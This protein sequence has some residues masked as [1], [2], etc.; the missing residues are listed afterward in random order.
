MQLVEVGPLLLMTVMLI[1]TETIADDQ[2]DDAKANSALVGPLPPSH[3]RTR[4]AS[5]PRREGPVNA[6]VAPAMVARQLR[7]C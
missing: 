4:A 6:A 1:I 2:R 3:P 5:D 7:K